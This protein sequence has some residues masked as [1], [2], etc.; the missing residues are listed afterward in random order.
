MSPPKHNAASCPTAVTN[1]GGDYSMYSGKKA[2]EIQVIPHGSEELISLPSF[3]VSFT[4]FYEDKVRTLSYTH[5]LGRSKGLNLKDGQF[6][7]VSSVV[8]DSLQPQ[9]P[10]HA[11]PPCLSPTPRVY[12]NSCPSS[13]WCHLTISFSVIPFS[14]CPQ[15]LPASGSFSMSQLVAWGGQSIGVSASTSILPMNTHNWSPLGWTGW[16]SLQSKGL[17]RVLSNTKRWTFT[18]KE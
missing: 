2:I 16:T 14:S 1:Q 6:S 11:R 9:A 17:S 7:S 10:Q 5:E 12:P 18:L 3:H 13:Q 15:S 8:S 4:R